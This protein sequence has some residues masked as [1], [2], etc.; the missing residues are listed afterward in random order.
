MK[1]WL[2]IIVSPLAYLCAIGVAQ[3]SI[4]YPSGVRASYTHDKAGHVTAASAGYNNKSH[5]KPAARR[6]SAASGALDDRAS[7]QACS[8]KR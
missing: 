8:V 2:Q 3:A 1:A 4:T 5:T 6:C 7:G